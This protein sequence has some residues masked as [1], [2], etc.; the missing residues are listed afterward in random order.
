MAAILSR[1]QCAKIYVLWIT[2]GICLSFYSHFT[3][4]LAI[5]EREEMRME[6]PP[7]QPTL[8]KTFMKSLITHIAV[9]ISLRQKNPRLPN[10]IST[11]ILPR[12]KTSIARCPMMT[13]ICLPMTIHCQR[14]AFPLASLVLEL[15]LW[16]HRRRLRITHC[17]EEIYSHIDSCVFDKLF[18]NLC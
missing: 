6:T 9:H 18:A 15:C 7:A 12:T 3:K 1:P 17:M 13:I 16:D 4:S 5:T 11:W 8:P 10:I 2:N 14:R